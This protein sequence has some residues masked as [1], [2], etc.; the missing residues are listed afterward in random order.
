MVAHPL[1]LTV[2]LAG[3]LVACSAPTA[4]PPAVDAERMRSEERRQQDLVLAGGRA[5]HHSRQRESGGVDA[6]LAAARRLMEVGWRILTASSSLCPDHLDAQA[7]AMLAT[8]HDIPEALRRDYHARFHFEDEALVVA[9]ASGSPADRAGLRLGDVV[10]AVGGAP[11]APSAR[12]A[13]DV[14]QLLAE[15]VGQATAIG[16]RRDGADMVVDLTPVPTCRSRLALERHGAVNAYADGEVVAAHSGLLD[17]L[18]DD[19]HLATV[20]GHEI[21]HNIRGHLRMQAENEEAGALLGN[22]LDRLTGA[23][24]LREHWAGIGGRAFSQSFETEA[25]YV[26]LY[27]TAL[28]GYDIAKAPFLWRRMA[29]ANPFT[30]AHGTT[31]P[32]TPNRFVLLEETVREIEAKRA[33]GQALIPERR[34]GWF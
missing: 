4:R 34:K 17:F 15:R 9:V 29:V 3:L 19:D 20:I 21:A 27:L 26:G 11:V 25:D 31:H 5:R 33:R 24:D 14:E 23:R 13:R 6:D 12:A 28:A 8:I 2:L 10:V 7:G 22:L 16:F 32:T 1:A 30:I 18:A